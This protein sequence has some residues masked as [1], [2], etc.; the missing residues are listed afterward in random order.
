MHSQLL[1]YLGVKMNNFPRPV[2]FVPRAGEMSGGSGEDRRPA[3]RP[4]EGFGA[5]PFNI[6]DNRYR[7]GP[8]PCY[9]IL[10]TRFRV[11]FLG[12]PFNIYR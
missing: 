12:G 5:R 6:I 11:P 9:C 10:G 8:T 7:F 3:G 1:Y 2:D 4:G